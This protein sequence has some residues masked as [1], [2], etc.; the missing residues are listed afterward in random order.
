MTFDPRADHTLDP[1]DWEAFRA[2]AH[3]MVDD[4]LD[5]QRTL[6]ERRPWS[7]IPAEVRASLT[8]APLPRDGVGAETA[9]EQ[10]TREI[11][12]YTNGNRHPRFWGWIQGNGTPLGMMSDMLAAGMNAH[13]AGLDQSP[14][15]VELQ[16]IAWLAELM[17]FPKSSSGILQSGG[18]MANLIGLA[19]ARHARAG[20]D[21]R[22]LGVRGGPQ[23]TVYASAEVH[24]WARRACEV[25]GLGA[26]ALRSVP[27]DDALRMEMGALRAAIAADR[28]AGH[29]PICVIGTAGTVN[30]AA[31]DDLD[32]IADLCAAE[33]LWFHVDGAFGA[34][35]RLSPELAPIVR[36]MERA[37]SLAFDLHKWGYLPYE[38]ACVL[39]RDAA[40]HRDTFA[41][42]PSYL[43]DEGRGVIAGG[44]PFY[45]RG[46]ELTR[47]FKALKVW[48]S[49]RAQGVSAWTDLI[50]QNVAQARAFAERVVALPH[51]VLAAPV[52]LNVVA[53]RFA[54]PGVAPERADA[55]TKEV[56][57]RV[58]ESGV[59]V[60]SGSQ[61][62]GRYVIRVA[63][64]NHRTRWSDFETL[65]AALPP[66]LTEAMA[67]V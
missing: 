5:H 42:A 24:G 59:G 41:M 6:S 46:I 47:N 32:A 60:P 61:V 19:V 25:L 1:A 65:L 3:R 39:V 21:V 9:Y 67:A 55:I 30:T 27:V 22:A 52:S 34:L 4:S 51:V 56:L 11:L 48:M 37:D 66:L 31:T 57:L 15:L 7:P 33:G 58:Q 63:C 10:F 16:V 23:L 50:E 2:L 28:A 43:R 8:G 45:E 29:R 49:L 35:A 20:F 38:I 44:I 36:G 12:P 40:A 54:P 62:G 13:M 17:G 14:K 26:D 64:S 18:T 53:F